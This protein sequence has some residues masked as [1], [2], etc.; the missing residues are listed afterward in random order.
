MP[1]SDK[2][3]AQI[4]SCHMELSRDNGKTRNTVLKS[5][6]ESKSSILIKEDEVDEQQVYAAMISAEKKFLVED[7]EISSFDSMGNPVVDTAKIEDHMISV[8][9][10]R[11]VADTAASVSS[12]RG[13]S[14]Y[15]A[16]KSRN[17]GCSRGSA[18]SYHDM[19][20]G[21]LSRILSGK[22]IKPILPP[23]TALVEPAS[24]PAPMSNNTVLTR[25]SRYTETSSSSSIYL[26]NST[27]LSGRQR[28]QQQLVA[29]SQHGV[30]NPLANITTPMK[31]DRPS[32][33]PHASSHSSTIAITTSDKSNISLTGT[34]VPCPLPKVRLPR[35]YASSNTTVKIEPTILSAANITTELPVRRG[36]I[37]SMDID[38]AGLDFPDMSVD[39]IANDF[40]VSQALPPLG[41]STVNKHAHIAPHLGAP[42][43]MVKAS[44]APGAISNISDLPM[45]SH[46]MSNNAINNSG[47][48]RAMSFEF[49]SLG[50][51][52]DEPLPPATNMEP[53]LTSEH[54]F[55]QRPR[56]D[57]LIFDPASF[58]DGGIH[59]EKAGNMLKNVGDRTNTLDIPFGDAAEMAIL[60][61][62]GLFAGATKNVTPSVTSTATAAALS[63]SASEA[64]AM[65]APMSSSIP[66]SLS[67]A[68]AAVAAASVTRNAITT[69]TTTATNSLSN[70]HTNMELLNKDG[71]I[72]IYLPDQRRARIA[73]FH[74]K[75][76]MR[77][78]KKRIKYDCR[79]KL[80]DSRPRIKG[81]FVKRADSKATKT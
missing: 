48:S 67:S 70:T 9:L 27:N 11:S 53:T 73:K 54:V 74:S 5:P 18:E 58:Q 37:F 23:P 21:V 60:N 29:T 51:N 40:G 24:L 16:K 2:G 35:S 17:D 68:A 55:I 12:G 62:P 22:I 39:T 64:V 14:S 19:S 47:R 8:A 28:Q 31:H 61:T 59:E 79:K 13:H 43:H 4:M 30:P 46:V 25:K 75:R 63:F 42:G 44:I 15:G 78:W 80:A 1:T 36:R 32:L 52:A 38:P 77:I 50:I 7:E 41:S 69:T 33:G 49:F 65:K 26:R 6:G 71:R 10:A 34:T 56:G 81:R 3:G 57:S 76:K 20:T 72:G 45:P 66:E